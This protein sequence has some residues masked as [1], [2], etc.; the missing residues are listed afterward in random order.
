MEI[1]LSP[2]TWDKMAQVSPDMFCV[3]DQDGTFRRVSA[4]SKSMLGY[5][6]EELIGR[7]YSDLLLPDYVA[8]TQN[9]FQHIRGGSQ[10]DS[11]ENGYFH[12][13]GSVVP[14]LW[15][16]VWSEDENVFF[17]VARN[18]AELKSN[19]QK[20]EEGEQ[21]YKT[22]FENN[23]DVMFVQDRQGL[24]LE[25]NQSFCD[26]FGISREEAK[27]RPTTSFLPPEMVPLCIRYFQESLQGNTTRYE[28]D[29]L[30]AKNQRRTFDVVKFPIYSNSG[31]IR[32]IKTILKDI[33]ETVRSFETIKQQ[34]SKLNTIFESITDAFITLDRRNKLT[35][36]NREAERLLRL[37]RSRHIGKDIL[38]LF[39]QE[40]GGEFHRQ[41]SKALETGTAV[42]FTSF[43]NEL[44]LWFRVNAYPSAEG[45][46]VYFDDVTEQVKAQRDLE[47]LS[48]VASKVNNGVVIADKD[49]RI[50]W[51]NEGF[52]KL[53]GYCLEEA[54]GKKPAELLC[55]SK[56]NTKA[57]DAV[58]DRIFRGEYV[59][60]E[61]LNSKKNGEDIW[62]SVQV[63]PSLDESGNVSSLVAIQTDV[64]EKKKYEQE[65]EKLSLV[66]SGTDNGVIITDANGLTEW[67]NE[68]FTKT[69]G[70][71][72]SEMRGNKPGLL[73][74]GPETEKEAVSTMRENLKKGVHFNTMLIN[75]KKSGEKFWV[76][77]DITPIHDSTGSLVQFI[78][79]QKDITFRKEA[80]ANVLKLTQDLY[81]QN[82]DLQQFTYLVSHNLRAPVANALGLTHLLTKLDKN[83][84][85]FNTSLSNLS[86]SVTQLDTVLKDM[87][88]ILSVRDSKGNLELEQI[89]VCAVLQEAVSSLQKS[90]QG[91]G[92]EVVNEIAE[93]LHVWANKA[94]LYS[95]FYNLLSNAIKYRSDDRVLRV[96][97]RASKNSEKGV[98]ISFV[99]NGSGF[100]MQKAKDKVFKLYKRF[101]TNKQGRG[102]G[103][104]LVK[105]HL[106][107]MGGDIQVTSLVGEGT[108]FSIY[109]PTS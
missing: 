83:S 27:G 90:L 91:C 42:R 19:R 55:N 16:G 6:R 4:A 41:Y 69:T 23:P 38:E 3:F 25:V 79:I 21:L 45:L 12:K 92:A 78:A 54:V 104:Y 7:H 51:V 96:H 31:E 66:A 88:T 46:S 94:Y 36:L 26:V 65:L 106:E 100:D 75:Y 24:V 18:V 2:A 60:F 101:H 68:G 61:I 17:C 97:L 44:G 40:V 50:E 22:L 87:N 99:D 57:Y 9:A 14:I 34:A 28:L 107:T 56:T 30:T 81:R 84:E 59:S 85:L 43:M 37:D 93:D 29:L 73:L 76:S 49:D 102:I 33:T 58:R 80:E 35:Y 72:L 11:F 105:N 77:M 103:L 5:E 15:Y 67:V 70:Y 32:Y 62:L 10:A 74:Q 48:L 20:L 8:I 63:S 52:T 47:K 86:Q 39:P 109:L 95:I 1:G 13:N 98:T 71:T 89:N 53:T 64:T 82:S 108:T